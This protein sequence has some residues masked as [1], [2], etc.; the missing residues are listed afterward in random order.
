MVLSALILAS[1]GPSG[2]QAGRPRVASHTR[3]GAQRVRGISTPPWL[4]ASRSVANPV[5]C[6]G[7]RCGITPVPVIGV[8]WAAGGQPPLPARLGGSGRSARS[9]PAAVLA[10]GH[11]RPDRRA[12]RLIPLRYVTPFP[13]LRSSSAAR[14]PNIYISPGAAAVAVSSADRPVRDSPQRYSLRRSSAVPLAVA[15]GA[16]MGTRPS[17]QAIRLRD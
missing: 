9:S 1:W 5:S 7:W 10:A 13:A 11:P 3:C 6:P 17:R 8:P 15:P 14:T 16:V 2:G 12:V 4:R